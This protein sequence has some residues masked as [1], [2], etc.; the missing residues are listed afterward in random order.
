MGSSLKFE[1]ANIE[2]RRSRVLD[3]LAQGLPQSHIAEQL[4]VSPATISLDI[5]YL[6]CSAKQ[7]IEKQLHEVLPM[8]Y[9]KTMAGLNQVLRKTWEIVNKEH[10]DD[11]TKLQSLALVNECYRLIMELS[12]D[13]N[14]IKEAM[15]FVRR[16][17]PTKQEEDRVIEEIL[18]GSPEPQQQAAEEDANEEL[19]NQAD[20]SDS[21]TDI[22]LNEE[23]EDVSEEQEE[24]EEVS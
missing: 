20:T 14:V 3:L 13:G 6:E 15:A 10:V 16:H 18:R 2:L 19:Q 23:E 5:Q 1:R 17:T 9:S 8:Q 24:Q 4:N 11:K 22:R 21:S 7:N 12:S